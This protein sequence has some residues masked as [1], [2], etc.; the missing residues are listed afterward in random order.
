[1]EILR[2]DSGFAFLNFGERPRAIRLWIKE[3]IIVDNEINF[4]IN[5][6][7]IVRTQK[8]GFV[9]VPSKDHCTFLVNVHSGFRGTSSISI[10]SQ[11]D[12]YH[13]DIYHSPRGSL[14]ISDGC[15]VST[16]LKYVEYTWKKTGRLYGHPSEG[17]V[18]IDSDGNKTELILDNEICEIMNEDE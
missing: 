4:P 2:N 5:G 3:D 15:L 16:P 14:G 12:V 6:A 13:F 9:L 8:G 7:K 1:M 17:G 11:G 10:L 18:R